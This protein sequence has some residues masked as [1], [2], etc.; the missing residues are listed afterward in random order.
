[1]CTRN[2]RPTENVKLLT[3]EIIFQIE[4]KIAIVYRS[5]YKSISITCSYV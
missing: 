5:N 3:Y 2:I 4:I 1:M